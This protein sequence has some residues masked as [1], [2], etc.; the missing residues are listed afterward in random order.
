[1]RDTSLKSWR[2][3]RISSLS[4]KRETRYF[5]PQSSKFYCHNSQC[6]HHHSAVCI[7]YSCMYICTQITLNIGK[8]VTYYVAWKG[9]CKWCLWLCDDVIR[10]TS[11]SRLLC[12]L[13]RS[14]CCE[15]WSTSL[16]CCYHFR[17]QLSYNWV[18]KINKYTILPFRGGMLHLFW[19]LQPSPLL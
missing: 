9:G 4:S 15:G 12:R 3:Y 2:R 5:N 11:A 19:G 17:V 13:L 18:N 10:N 6:L 14:P 16:C 1:M 7:I 8:H